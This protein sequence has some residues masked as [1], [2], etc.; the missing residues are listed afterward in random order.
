LYELQAIAKG[1]RLEGPQVKK[2]GLLVVFLGLFVLVAMIFYPFLTVIIWSI[3]F[4][5]FLSPLYR[6]L[7][8]RRDG[9]ERSGF[10]RT[11]TA[12]CL[13]F[14][15]VLL[16]AVPA[17]LLGITMVKQ[18]SSILRET[19]VQVERNPSVIGL[20]PNGPVLSLLN[21][22]SGGSIDFS[23]VDVVGRLRHF[24]SLR[25]DR[26]IGLSGK[27][28]KDTLGIVVNLLFMI[29]TIFFLLID[30]RHLAKA[31]ISAIPIEKNYTRIFMRKFRDMGVHLISGYFLIAVLQA[32]IMLTLCTIFS[33][34]GGLVIGF[35]TALASFIPMVGTALVWLPVSA[36]KFLAGDITGAILFFILSAA[37][38]WT[39]DNLIR[40]LLLH[41][42]LKIHPLLILFSI[43][44]GISV[45]KFNG[46]VL[47][48]LILILFFTAIELYEQVY[49]GSDSDQNR[50]KDDPERAIIAPPSDAKGD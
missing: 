43:L 21:T 13:A 27:I 48:P 50:R 41:D 20:D 49:E 25:A 37:L 22:L 39:A 45:F 5:G 42:K 10:V 7:I 6:K 18:L 4:Y 35:L 31:L 9:T 23:T 30:G 1:E 16:I 44:G 34:K 32:L 47:G 36:A 12:G 17:V 29:F 11:T 38:I 24:F 3:L 19:L 40:P 14:G 26:I 33:V 28:I 8:V 46:I 2:L 15:G